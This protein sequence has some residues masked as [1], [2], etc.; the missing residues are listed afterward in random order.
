MNETV[1]HAHPN[2]P[3]SVP[4]E[5]MTC[6]SCVRRV[7]TAAAKVPGVASSSVNFATK[8][9]TVEPAEGFSARTLGAA[10]KKVGYDIA[11]E[12]QEFA[13]DGLH[14]EA[15]AE[16][17]K[18]VL[19][20][21]ATT[22]NVKVD[23][24]A[25][26]VAVEIIGGRRE[27]DAL[28]ETAKLAG[29]VLKTPKL[30]DQSAHHDHGQYHAHHQGH[31][32]MAAAGESGGHDHMQHAGEEGALKRDL[33]IAA[34]LTAPLFVL[35]MGGHI[36][37]PMHHW[38]MGI[39]ETQ[40]LYYIYFVL[41]TAVIF[42]PGLRFLKTGFPALLRG[43][44]EMNSLVALGVTAAYLYSVVATFAPDLLPAEA[45]FV[46]YEAA[47]VIVTL[48]LTG[49]LLEA[50]ASGRTGD[51]IRKLMSLQAKTARVERDGATIDISPDDLVA[52][53]IIVIRPGER[54]AVDGEVVEGSSYVDESMISGEPVPVEKTVGATVVGGTINKT[55]AF[56]FKAT[57]VGADTMLS[58]IIRMVEEAQG[59][60]LPIQLLVDR[61]TALFV[62]V[63]I[64]IAVLTFIVWAIFG[65]E[66]AYTFALVNAVAVLIIACP[67]AMGL[68]TP[69]SI[70]VGTGRA[71]ELG[72]L[73][74]KGQALQ[75]LRSAQIVVVDKTGTVTKGRP[76]LTDLVVAEGFAD[77]EVLALVAAVEGRSE[78]PIAEAIVRAA[79]EK[80]VATPAG[81][82]P[83]TVENF[84]SVTGYGIAATVNGRKVEVGADRYMAKLGHSVDIFAEAA[85]RLGDEG[86]TPLY[87]AIDGR[88]AGAIAVADPLKPS[89]VTAIKAL[90]A[91]GIEVAMVT[92]D[93]ERTANAIARQVGISRVVAEVLP[94]GKVKAIH[95]MRAG[96]KVLAF[97]GDGIND[98]PALAEA[99]IG[100]AV[101]TGTDVAIESA[102]VVLVGGDLLGAVNAIEMSRATMRNIK[103]NLFW[104][105]GY[106]VAL[107]PVAAGVLYPAFG[108]TLS[109][110]I[111]AG[112]MALSSVFV[113][114]NALRLK[115]AKVV[116][117]EVTS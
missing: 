73:F 13:V 63:V 72:V 6:A 88:L 105:F 95:E 15:E 99:D 62:P 31:S 79:E 89:S 59:S 106:N 66:P 87:A 34:I 38:L 77:N 117:R 21:V 69:T 110:M 27:R 40:N 98:A 112:A 7:E 82:A 91:M 5:G 111:G 76:E 104:A 10:I 86:K 28:V 25:G 29:F 32:Q 108:I 9:L 74:R 1:R 102:D 115:R 100:I 93:N 33:T 81:L 51:A 107:I 16:R 45:Q 52:G 57:K 20:A 116:H 14:G 90:Q 80:N 42:G 70:M 24:S 64:A 17:L 4:V 12:R 46:Y 61:V 35:E 23:A 101:G 56:K 97:V 109:P 2:Q 113:L 11:P 55:G 47:T 58:Q 19:D 18:A 37:E 50:R 60:K 43:A 71:A 114:A 49:R 92:G 54:L 39:I 96:G 65:P 48:I 85:A 8:K 78:H 83:T 68:A 30:H 44:P 75:E 22:V 84:E 67:C 41:A 103:E 94:E 26:K 53:D 36:Y 3:V